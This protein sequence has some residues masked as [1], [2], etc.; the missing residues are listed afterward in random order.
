MSRMKWGAKAVAVVAASALALS[1]CGGGTEDPTGTDAGAGTDTATDAP[2]AE[3]GTLTAAAA[4]TTTNFPPSSTSSALAMGSNWHVVEGLWELD[5]TTYEPFKALAA[6]DDLVEVTE[7]QYEVA[8]RDG[9]A[10]SDGTPVTA[11]DVATSFDR[12]T[13]E[14]NIYAPML[15][16]ITSIEAKDETT[17][18]INT[19]F[20]TALLKQRLTLIKIVPA[21][22]TDEDL[23]AMPIGTG[24]WAY[25]AI[26][27]QSVSF[28]PNENYNGDF[29]ATADNMEWQILVDDTARTTAMQQGTVSVMESVPADAAA[30]IEGSGA[31]VEA[32]QGFNLPF[33]MFNT[34]KAPFDDAKVRQAFFY[35][36]DT[37]KLIDNALSGNATP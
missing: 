12:A 28:T 7:T 6:T 15:S 18:T 3:G 2:A 33:L 16:F 32:V 10:F 21:S 13:A 9:A 14:G 31:I 29:P 20:P 22:A 30:L 8:L 11:E 4:Y 23:T 5:L 26:T 27:E 35:A 37:Q 19:E 36:I 34:K 25:S 17:V 1:A 24:P